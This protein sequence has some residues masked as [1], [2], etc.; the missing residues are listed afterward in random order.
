MIFMSRM[1]NCRLAV[2]HIVLKAG[3]KGDVLET[4]L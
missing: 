1:V 2:N 3:E 4:G